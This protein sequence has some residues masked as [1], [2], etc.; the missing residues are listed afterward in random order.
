MK[1]TA[2]R[3]DVLCKGSN[4]TIYSYGKGAIKL[5]L[6]TVPTECHKESKHLRNEYQILKGLSHEGVIKVSMYK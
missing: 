6:K 1:I 2:D 5:A 4:S 3:L